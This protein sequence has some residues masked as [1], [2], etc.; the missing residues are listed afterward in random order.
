MSFAF[1]SLPIGIFIGYHKL[2]PCLG[3]SP[4]STW[5][6]WTSALA[7]AA[8][9]SPETMALLPFSASFPREE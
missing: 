8:H 2:P 1:G 6:I 7:V 3:K 4:D 5:T 9:M